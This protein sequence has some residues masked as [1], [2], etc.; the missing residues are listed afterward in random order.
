LGLLAEGCSK[1]SGNFLCCSYCTLVVILIYVK[2]VTTLPGLP[3]IPLAK[4]QLYRPL[5]QL[6]VRIKRM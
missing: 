1:T 6:S 4:D 3:R 2:I 5:D